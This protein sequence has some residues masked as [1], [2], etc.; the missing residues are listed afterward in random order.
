MKNYEGGVGKREMPPEETVYRLQRA[1]PHLMNLEYVHLEQLS[2]IKRQCEVECKNYKKENYPNR[3][4]FEVHGIIEDKYKN[5]LIREFKK[6]LKRYAPQSVDKVM[7]HAM[8]D[9]ATKHKGIK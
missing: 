4:P 8:D 2:D 5:M 9:L 7:Q 3:N 1:F 6:L